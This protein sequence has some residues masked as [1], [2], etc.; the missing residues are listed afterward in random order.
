VDRKAP[1]DDRDRVSL[2]V[3]GSVYSGWK[4][5]KI[6]LG[7]EQ[8]AGGFSLEVSDIW[9]DQIESWSISPGD[10]CVLKIGNETVITGYI[11]SVASDEDAGNHTINVQG[12]D[13]TGDLVDCSTVPREWVNQT[14]EFIANEV[15]KPF[16]IALLTQ[17]DTD[18]SGYQMKKAGKL[19]TPPKFALTGGGHL[20]R[21]AANPGETVHKLLER[22][23]KIQGVLLISD[24][25]GN[26]MVTQPG[27]NGKADDSLTV[28]ENV[29]KIGVEYSFANLFSQVTV[30]G[31]AHGAQTAQAPQALSAVK[32]VKPS[33]T[34]SR[35]A[36]GV[37]LKGSA[38]GRYRPLI[39]VADQQATQEQAQKRAAW[40]VGTREAKSQKVTCK[41][42]GWRQST[43]KLWTINTTVRVNAKSVRKK[44]DMLISKI[45]IEI[46]PQGTVCSMV[47]Y[48][49]GAFQVLQEIPLPDK[50]AGGGTG[51]PQRLSGA[52]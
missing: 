50:P 13:K 20:P 48:P 5:A 26:L 35:P 41:V 4:T 32:T 24:G 43:G 30:K 14:F 18:A 31:Q 44:Q 40:E 39:L 46:G 17:V 37:S 27:L 8:L 51:A 52:R 9:P 28:G 6:E 25:L 3:N 2:I 42:Q 34:I 49:P 11:D 16:G 47:L 29:L 45:S 36:P 1:I 21:K 7:I 15:M 19:K 33:A 23:A 22:L 38:I 12:R 10:S